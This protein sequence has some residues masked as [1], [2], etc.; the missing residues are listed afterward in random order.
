V[1]FLDF[2][3]NFGHQ[4]AVSAGLDHA[5]G[6]I[7]AIIDADLQDPPELLPQMLAQMQA[8]GLDVVYAQRRRRR[9]ETAFKRWSAKGFYRLL[10][11]WSSVD[12]PLDTG[13]FRLLTRQVAEAV[14]QMP[15]RQKFLRGQ[16]SWVGF[17]QAPFFYERDARFAGATKYPLRK[18]LRFAIDGLTGFSSIPLKFASVM[19]FF[20]SLFAFVLI[21]WVLFVRL[22]GSAVG[23]SV[24]PGWASQM[25]VTLF[26]GGVQLICIGILGEYLARIHEN[27]KARPLYVLRARSQ[28]LSA[29]EAP[30]ALPANVA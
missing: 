5:R 7:I 8:G 22:F 28:S 4:V 29:P 6:D 27:T 30:V 10:N 15:E 12:I 16:I 26:L 18:M 21:L 24:E 1:Q 11:D 2:A 3:R 25:L 19:G 9:G 13:D 14:R 23:Q 20:V 17:R